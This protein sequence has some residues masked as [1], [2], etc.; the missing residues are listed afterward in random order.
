MGFTGMVWKEGHKTAIPTANDEV[1][2]TQNKT[3]LGCYKVN[4]SLNK[5]CHI[6]F[7][8]KYWLCPKLSN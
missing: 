8:M 6:R 5:L 1:V 2:M 7:L 3:T 4:T